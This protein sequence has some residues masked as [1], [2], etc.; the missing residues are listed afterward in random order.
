MADHE[1]GNPE[2]E[3]AVLRYL[4]VLKHW[5]PANPPGFREIYMQKNH[6]FNKLVSHGFNLSCMIAKYLEIFTIKISDAAAIQRKDEFIALSEYGIDILREAL[7]AV[8]LAFVQVECTPYPMIS[9]LYLHALLRIATRRS[10]DTPFSAEVW[11]RVVT[12]LARL[13]AERKGYLA[14]EVCGPAASGNFLYQLRVTLRGARN[15]VPNFSAAPGK[16]KALT[17]AIDTALA[18]LAGLGGFGL[19]SGV[20]H[21]ASASTPGLFGR[22][23]LT[24]ARALP[25]PTFTTSGQPG[26]ALIRHIVRLAM[27]EPP[28][29]PA[30]D[31]VIARMMAANDVPTHEAL[32]M[33][34]AEFARAQ[35]A[36]PEPCTD[37][38][39]PI[40]TARFTPMVTEQVAG[41]DVDGEAPGPHGDA[42]I[43]EGPALATQR[44]SVTLVRV[45]VSLLADLT[46]RPAP[47]TDALTRVILDAPLVPRVVMGWLCDACQ[48]KGLSVPAHEVLNQVIQHGR[49]GPTRRRAAHMLINMASRGGVDPA[50]L[51]SVRSIMKAV[52]QTKTETR[53]APGTMTDLETVIDR[54]IKAAFAAAMN[55]LDTTDPAADRRHVPVRDVLVGLTRMIQA[56]TAVDG[57]RALRVYMAEVYTLY[58]SK[59][60]SSSAIDR[61]AK[62][63]KDTT[64]LAEKKRRYDP[65]FR[66]LA[67]DGLWLLHP[68]RPMGEGSIRFLKSL[69]AVEIGTGGSAGSAGDTAIA[70]L[71]AVAQSMVRPRAEDPLSNPMARSHTHRLSVPMLK[72]MGPARHTIQGLSAAGDAA[73]RAIEHA[74][75]TF[76]D[77]AL[78]GPVNAT[79]R[80]RMRQ[81]LGSRRPAPSAGGVDKRPRTG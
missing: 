46:A 4:G 41:D 53:P 52:G 79:A 29:G 75:R 11:T 58:G 76:P 68:R 65:L 5:Q 17:D 9:T 56:I 19:V 15:R 31:T 78:P 81:G 80:D 67:E 47:V 37:V 59:Y 39:P 71:T 51:N 77:V 62:A 10:D 48:D 61:M 50:A 36:P 40:R 57:G 6:V 24:A 13:A 22:L 1:D 73:A 72:S 34:W 26:E 60:T 70:Y 30:H 27:N 44:Y 35:T 8:Q 14:P 28:S 63:G 45:V 3:A 42:A 7:S 20:P 2:M 43:T 18:Q 16:Q 66:V 25:P 21:L 64:A 54:R 74:L 38:R 33:L 49:D 12:G 55:H 69:D 23:L 32:A